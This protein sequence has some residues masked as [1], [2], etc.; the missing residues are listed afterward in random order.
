[1]ECRLA[2]SR[3]YPA[4]TVELTQLLSA[5]IAL[6]GKFTGNNR[7]MTIRPKTVSRSIA[8]YRFQAKSFSS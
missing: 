7:E 3:R 1:M 4:I 2:G 8:R 5:S 6:R